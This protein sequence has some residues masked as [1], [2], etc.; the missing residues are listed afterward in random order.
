M[1]TATIAT[2]TVTTARHHRYY[3]SNCHAEQPLSYVIA[4]KKSGLALRRL[5]CKE[6]GE[7]KL[8]DTHHQQRPDPT[9]VPHRTPPTAAGRG[10]AGRH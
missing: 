3:C 7:H 1:A 9:A 2:A 5:P 4:L 8:C 10:N 6:C